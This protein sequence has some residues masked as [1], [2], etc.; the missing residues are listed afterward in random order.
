MQL[1]IPSVLSALRALL[2]FPYWFLR[3]VIGILFGWTRFPPSQRPPSDSSPT[4]RQ[5]PPEHSTT[6]QYSNYQ[7]PSHSDQPSETQ[8]L[9]PS[10]DRQQSQHGRTRSKDQDQL[11][12]QNPYYTGLRERANQEGDEVD[13]CFQ[14]SDEACER[15]E[16]VRGQELRE[17]GEEH[18]YAR[19]ALNAEASAW[20]FRENNL[21]SKPGEVNL[22]G[23]YVKEAISYS[24]KAIKEAR[25]RGDSQI[26][27]IVG[28]GLHSDGRISRIKP[29]ME[30]KM[31][32]CS[33]LA[34]VDPR[35]A[36]VLIVQLG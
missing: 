31:R 22:H 4:Y 2:K 9:P 36:G 23:L 26:R 8:D 33:L 13:R 16:S 10:P 21:N 29:A 18:E 11:N 35:N 27:L 20:I 12:K 17:E 1:S 15:G 3:K 28:K 5:P 6:S 24:D 32:Q 19:D 25:Q 14:Q 30:K 34:E 7:T